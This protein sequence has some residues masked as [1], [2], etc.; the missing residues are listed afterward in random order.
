MFYLFMFDPQ[1]TSLKVEICGWELTCI[2]GNYA[3]R[4]KIRDVHFR[5]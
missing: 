5:G 3:I 4:S 2:G 1:K